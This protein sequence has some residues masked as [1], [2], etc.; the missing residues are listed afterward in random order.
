MDDISSQSRPRSAA[1][2]IPEAEQR[3]SAGPSVVVVGAGFGGLEAV[4]ALATCDVRVV[5][6]G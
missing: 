5:V 4:K 2:S 3:E 1:F 6:V